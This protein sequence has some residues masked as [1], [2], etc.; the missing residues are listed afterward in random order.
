MALPT[1]TTARQI[2]AI[3]CGMLAG[4]TAFAM[5]TWWAPGYGAW[6][7]LAAALLTL[8]TVWLVWRT[9]SARRTVPGNPVYLL[10]LGP[11]AVA[12]WQAVAS[13]AGPAE[14]LTADGWLPASM[15]LHAG[16]LAT[17]VLVA[18]SLLA[19][20]WAVLVCAG[21]L[22][23]GG[24]TAAGWQ[25]APPMPVA[26]VGLTGA[27][28]WLS[29]AGS[30]EAFAAGLSVRRRMWRVLPAVPGI[31]AGGVYGVAVPRAGLAAAGTAGLLLTGCGLAA[32]RRRWPQL[33]AGVALLPA[34]AV[35]AWASITAE[36]VARPPALG[37]AERGFTEVWPGDAGWRVLLA[38][39]GWAGAGTVA[40]AGLVLLAWCCRRISARETLGGYFA[41][42]GAIL[43]GAALL[44]RGGLFL[45]AATL[46]AG[47]AWGLLPGGLGAPR[48]ERTGAA[49]LLLT[50]VVLT[51]LGL[52][53][54]AGLVSWIAVRFQL[55]DHFLHVVA[56]VLVAL[57]LG[58]LLGAKRIR[59][60]LIGIALAAGAGLGAEIVQTIA[61]DRSASWSDWWA[62]LAG[63]VVGG[64]LYLLAAG[65]RAAESPDVRPARESASWTGYRE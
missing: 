56:G 16:L 5:L 46:A 33:L 61:S 60:G 26:L 62:H 30:R 34:L 9:V 45:P 53:R 41:A 42:A 10:L 58:W 36:P 2:R 14:S 39:T 50:L 48:R 15:I 22:M 21:A 40:V 29:V 35:V 6:G 47:L 37:W 54:N 49:V 32:P 31:V 4:G 44:S 25:Q 18:Q 24:L 8:L 57:E 63:C 43:A 3:G 1:G 27:A 17:A 51:G 7:G 12:S 65:S 64:M 23:L 52:V 28:L 11:L 20:R 38:T 19:T 13:V 59:G 55:G